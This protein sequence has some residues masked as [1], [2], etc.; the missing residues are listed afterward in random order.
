[1]NP[2]SAGLSIVRSLRV[3]R[4]GPGG[5][6]PPPDHSALGEVLRA[7]QA[8][9]AAVLPDQLDDLDHYTATMA[10]ARP[11]LLS[12]SDAL[13][14]WLN[15][16]N[17]GALTLA[18]ETL[19]TGEASVLRLPGAFTRPVLT[20][21]GETLS[22]DN[23]EHGKIRRFQDPRIHA[24][25]VCGSASCPT[26]RHEPYDGDGL[27]GQLDDQL[28]SFLRAGGAVIEDDRLMLSRVFLW[29]GADF[30][31]P[32]RMP[33]LIPARRSLIARAVTPW[34]PVH[35]Q[36]WLRQSKR[37]IAFQDYDWSVACSVRKP[38]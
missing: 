34:L 38:A 3:R 25:L 36:Q 30:V 32:H 12:R 11:D 29:Y 35:Q 17:A 26:L 4:P 5:D 20:V 15:L 23:I 10:K 9:G 18:G 6:D 2:L 19:S 22:L 1:P 13:A 24:A 21:A 16:Y 8:G 28:R 31:R 14:F 33:A 7:V 27:T 37:S